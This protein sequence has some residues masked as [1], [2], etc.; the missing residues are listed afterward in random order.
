MPE[1][2]RPVAN[3]IFRLTLSGGV[4]LFA[5]VLWVGYLVVRSPYEMMQNVPREQPLP[6][7]HEHHV[8][9]LGLD[10]RYCHVSVE[11]SSFADIPPTSI[12]LNCHSQMW[13]AAPALA[14][15]H[16][17]YR[18]GQ[19]IQWTKVYELPQYVYFDHSIHIN[20]GIG[21]S[22]CHGRVDE[23][24]LTWQSPNLTMSW[25]LS[26]HRNPE[27]H[28]RPKAEVFNMSYR[29]PPDQQALGRRLVREYGIKSLTSCSICHR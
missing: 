1:P 24:P 22:D 12:C 29:Q 21:C 25:C 13:A 23:M 16:E 8:G 18:T 14:P 9:G 17:S 19:S 27:M 2:F 7:S 5:F 20:K 10:C 15:V 4:A 28:V 3:T 6:F 26:C 11:V